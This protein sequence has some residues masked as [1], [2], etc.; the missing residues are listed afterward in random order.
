MIL[1]ILV[2]N[3]GVEETGNASQNLFF[4]AILHNRIEIAKIFWRVGRV[5]KFI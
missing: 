4:W 1:I 5:R 3:F 2:E